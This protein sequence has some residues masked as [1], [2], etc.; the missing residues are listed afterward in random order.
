MLQRQLSCIPFLSALGALLFACTSK[1]PDDGGSNAGTSGGT[2]GTGPAAGGSSAASGGAGGSSG[3]GAGG[4]TV[5]GGTRH[6]RLRWYRFRRILPLSALLA[7]ISLSAC[8]SKFPGECTVGSQGCGCGTASTCDPGLNCQSGKCVGPGNSEPPRG[9]AQ[10]RFCPGS[11]DGEAAFT[12]QIADQR[13]EA[14]T[15]ACAPKAGASCIGVSSGA[16][17]LQLQGSPSA[18][19][20]ELQRFEAGKAYVVQVQ[21]ATIEGKKVLAPR[22]VELEKAS[23]CGSLDAKEA[24]FRTTAPVALELFQADGFTFARPKNYVRKGSDARTF[25]FEPSNPSESDIARFELRYLGQ[26]PAAGAAAVESLLDKA[27]ADRKLTKVAGVYVQPDG[28]H[29]EAAI[30]DTGVAGPDRYVLLM[31]H[32]HFELLNEYREAGGANAAKD[33][34]TAEFAFGDLATFELRSLRSLLK[35]IAWGISIPPDPPPTNELVGGTWEATGGVAFAIGFSADGTYELTTHSSNACIETIVMPACPPLETAR[36]ISR[37]R[38]QAEGGALVLSP[39]RCELQQTPPEG[40]VPYV[41]AC[42]PR[43]IPTTLRMERAEG[44]RLR[45]GGL[46]SGY[47]LSGH[48]LLWQAIR[49]GGP[50]GS[51]SGPAPLPPTDGG[52]AGP[53]ESICGPVNEVEP[54]NVEESATKLTVGQETSACAPAVGDIDWYDFAAPAAPAPGYFLATIRDAGGGSA[55]LSTRVEGHAVRADG[56]TDFTLPSAITADGQELAFAWG[57]V[58]GQRFAL[59]LRS[60]AFNGWYKY[61]LNVS[62]KHLDDPFEANDDKG[63]SPLTLGTP[64]QAYF[65]AYQKGSIRQGSEDHFTVELQIGPATVTLDSVPSNLT[66]SLSV[67]REVPGEPIGASVYSTASRRPPPTAGESLT[68]PLQITTAGKHHVYLNAGFPLYHLVRNGQLPEH[69]TKPYRLLVTQ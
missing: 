21:S 40:K 24:P 52:G 47:E 42:P 8:K 45:F 35:S 20:A 64:T 63:G 30:G 60:G 54:N 9:T 32:N 66:P 1:A 17:Q 58:P 65:L 48:Q 28:H 16:V 14:A 37:G 3:T 29:Y 2:A 15:G 5:T 59:Q 22:V 50:P 68:I 31:Y 12:L 62:F 51:W 36:T 33:V 34:F 13:L 56:L 7:V 69:L 57:A 53:V 11:I 44:G 61:L 6:K 23:D 25:R 46:G 26:F 10:V 41:L 67:S 49:K 38:Y 39:W 27:F 4:S 18:S 55:K 19:P 43:S